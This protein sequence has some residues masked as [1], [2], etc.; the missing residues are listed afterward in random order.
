MG[1]GKI[2]TNA[3]VVIIFSLYLIGSWKT[4]CVYFGNGV[5]PCKRNESP[6]NFFVAIGILAFSILF[7]F[8]FGFVRPLWDILS[9]K[10]GL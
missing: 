7:L 2:L 10:F 9:K 8:S 5:K 6:A 1:Y 3:L 4:G